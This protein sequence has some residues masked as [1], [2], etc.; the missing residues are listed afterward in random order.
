MSPFDLIHGL[1]AIKIGFLDGGVFVFD[2]ISADGEFEGEVVVNIVS[3]V[4]IDPFDIGGSLLFV[5]SRK[6]GEEFV[7]AHPE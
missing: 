1:I 5:Y 6:E 7:S 3:D 4:L 2:G